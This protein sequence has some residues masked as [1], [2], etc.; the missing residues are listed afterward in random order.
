M[1]TRK[2]DKTERENWLRY[3]IPGCSN[4]HRMKIN[5]INLSV[6]NTKEHEM[7]KC[8]YAYDLMKEG[9]KVLTEAD[10]IS[11]GKRRDLV[12]ISNGEIY[13]FETDEKR[14]IRHPKN[15]NVIMVKR[16]EV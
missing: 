13:E 3:K 1:K 4:L 5:A 15:I 6:A 11:T 16:N 14:A 9:F 8:S 10:E 2:L 12:D 7:A